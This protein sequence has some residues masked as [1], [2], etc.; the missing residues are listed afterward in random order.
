MGQLENSREVFPGKGREIKDVSVYPGAQL[1]VSSPGWIV[2]PQCSAAQ[3]TDAE[4]FCELRGT[5]TS[6]PFTYAATVL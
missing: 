5:I 6:G 3:R 1:N 4:S 2:D